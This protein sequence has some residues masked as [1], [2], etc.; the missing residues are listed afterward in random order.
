M[1]WICECPKM[2]KLNLTPVNLLSKFLGNHYY[3]YQ[4]FINSTDKINKRHLIQCNVV[5]LDLRLY[6]AQSI[7]IN[8][9][10]INSTKAIKKRLL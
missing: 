3:V 10:F 4:E 5:S 7:F 9:E 1:Y 6:Y 8:Q 2:K